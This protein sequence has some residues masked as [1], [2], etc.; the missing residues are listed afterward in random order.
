MIN[1]NR[2]INSFRHSAGGILLP[3]LLIVL[4]C[5]STRVSGANVA[6]PDNHDVLFVLEIPDGVKSF[7]IPFNS[8]TGGDKF[9]IISRAPALWSWDVGPIYVG[10]LTTSGSSGVMEEIP[11]PSTVQPGSYYFDVQI[12]FSFGGLVCYSDPLA[13]SLLISPKGASVEMTI[14]S[15]ERVQYTPDYTLIREMSAYKW[16]RETESGIA[17]IAE[18]GVGGIDEVLTCTANKPVEVRYTYII[19]EED[20]EGEKSFDV[21]VTVKPSIVFSIEN[22][23]PELC[24]GQTTDIVIS[25]AIFNYRWEVEESDV[26][27]GEAGAGTE[28]HQVL[29]YNDM[30]STLTYKVFPDLEGCFETQYTSVKI[31]ALPE[32][33]L[34]NF[35]VQS[36]AF[37]KAI[38]IK[39]WPDSYEKY[40]FNFNGKRTEQASHVL[41]CYE[42]LVNANNDVSVSVQSEDGCENDAE[43]HLLGPEMKL[44]NIFIPNGDGTNDVFYSGF[45][46][47]VYNLNGSQ[48]YKGKDGWDGRYKNRYVPTGTYLYIVKAITEEGI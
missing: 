45:E 2:Y 17:E 30:S 35:S 23:T 39:A 3:L 31:K 38:T 8:L 29:T 33:E 4:L 14:C 15:G 25:P 47:E 28:I 40:I 21:L 16:R 24:S 6:V 26:T 13:V 1:G 34:E 10:D 46:L 9:R 22:F 5:S 48:L 18:S 27:G 11:I 44:P 7:D 19:E 43:L 37:G 42:W 12:G 41:K 20:Y 36:V 32:V